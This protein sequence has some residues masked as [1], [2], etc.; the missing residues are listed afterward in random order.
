MKA[1]TL[2]L[3]ITRDVR[4]MHVAVVWWIV[5]EHES[6]YKYMYMYMYM[7]VLLRSSD[8]TCRVSVGVTWIG[9][10]KQQHVAYP[11]L[12]RLMCSWSRWP[13][14][15]EHL[16]D[17]RLLVSNSGPYALLFTAF[18]Q[19]DALYGQNDHHPQLLC[20]YISRHVFINLLSRISK[21]HVTTALKVR[22]LYN[23]KVIYDVEVVFDAD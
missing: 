2:D 14:N 3:N 15:N 5:D 8:V 21:R 6:Q 20:Y 23:C 17:L 7:H 18:S 12:R 4:T 1:C 10:L 19:S 13:I 16:I 22:D 9:R 11:P